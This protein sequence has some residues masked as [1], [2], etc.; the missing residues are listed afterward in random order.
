L[1]D[2]MISKTELERYL[3][4]SANILRGRMD[5]ADFKVFVFP[6]LFFK[7]I[8]DVWNEEFEE[9]LRE[10]DG[11]LSYADFSENHRFQL[12]AGSRWK[13]IREVATD[14]GFAIQRAMRSIE[15]ANPTPLSG[16]FGDAQWT[17]KDRLP[18]AVLRDLVE[19]L[20]KLNLSVSNV[21]ADELGM[22]YEYLIR[23]FAD[24]SGHTAAEFYT[25]RTVVELMTEM[26]QPQ[27]GDSIYDP[28][29]GSGGMLLNSALYVAKKGMEHRSMR[30]YGQEL[31]LITSSIARMNL[32]L[33]GIEDF[34]IAREDTLAS[35]QFFKNDRL[36]QFDVVLANPPYSIK[37]WSQSAWSSDRYGRNLLG[38]PPA[39]CADWA[40]IQHIIT[41]LREGSGR[42]AILLPHGILFRDSEYEIRKAAIESGLVDAV[43]GLGANL[44]YNSPMESCILVLRKC[45]AEKTQQGVLFINAVHEIVHERGASFL[46]NE[47]ITRIA[48]AYEERVAVPGFCKFVQFDKIRHQNF[49][50]NISQYVERTHSNW[51][52]SEVETTVQERLKSWNTTFRDL[53]SEQQKLAT[54]LEQE[55][56][57]AN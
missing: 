39:S 12:P 35:P 57:D 34:A 38:T 11:D 1:G 44:F 28:T 49:T 13:D 51:E 22:G 8:S 20:S 26:M 10:A 23:K 46:S 6:L 40:F 14:L 27:P 19:H 2:L 30:L 53:V 50:L 37:R 18:D 31:N 17:N 24:D 33:H 4:D 9:A 55:L 32:F 41:S 21:P 54:V 16:I 7:R 52:L 42:A 45:K 56:S 29:C 3:W 25:N 15:E 36:Q 47:N 48:K 43:V 5:A